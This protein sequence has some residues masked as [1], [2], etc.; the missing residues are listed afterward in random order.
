MLLKFEA[1]AADLVDEFADDLC[2][3]R[4]L[5]AELG[6][7][8]ERR[9]SRLGQSPWLGTTE[10]A[11]RLGVVPRTLYRT[12]D[13]GLVLAYKMG[14]VIRVKSVDIDAFLESTRVEPGSLNHLYPQRGEGTED[15][16]A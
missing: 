13:E 7:V 9:Q 4:G 3:H 15:E 2:P 8:V 11:D 12:I 14:R 10:A 1:K 16:E 5:A 6:R